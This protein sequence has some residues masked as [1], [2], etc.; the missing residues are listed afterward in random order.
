MA[1]RRQ[2]LERE[3]K[4][5]GFPRAAQA[6]CAPQSGDLPAA[7]QPEHPGKG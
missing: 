1:V 2:L 7:P 4:K 6:R 5:L 3:L